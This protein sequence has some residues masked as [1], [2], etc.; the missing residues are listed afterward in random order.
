MSLQS[1]KTP[2][3]VQNNHSP[4]ALS[5]ETLRSE[6]ITHALL[7]CGPPPFLPSPR[8]SRDDRLCSSLVS[9]TDLPGTSMAGS[10]GRDVANPALQCFQGVKGPFWIH[11]SAVV[12]CFYVVSLS[13]VPISGKVSNNAILSFPWVVEDGNPG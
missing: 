7:A 1:N 10:G 8:C 11:L 6:T 4:R 2:L 5:L 9:V 3:R 12:P 13:N